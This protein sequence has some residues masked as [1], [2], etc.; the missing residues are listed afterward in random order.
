[1]AWHLTQGLCHFGPPAPAVDASQIF[2]SWSLPPVANRFP[3]GLNA[4]L[5]IAP[6]NVLR[7]TI[8]WPLAA[9]Q[10]VTAMPALPLT[11]RFPLRTEGDAPD[12]VGARFESSDL[13]TAGH[14][15]GFHRTSDQERR[16]Q[17]GA[18]CPGA[19]FARESHRLAELSSKTVHC[20]VAASVK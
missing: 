3:S 10:T 20:L 9:F 17:A 14:V 1:V 4:T 2:T 11:S 8:S 12:I 5:M 13:S 15:P 16:V 6:G 7:V 18:R 19:S